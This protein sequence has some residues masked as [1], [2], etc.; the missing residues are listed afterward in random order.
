M[1]VLIILSRWLHIIA[2]VLAF[3]GTFFMRVILPLGLAQAD[4]AS[5]DAVFLRCRRVF[6]MLIHTAVLLLLLTGAFNT[7]S[8]WNDYKLNT[9][10]MHGLWG[11]HML[12][13]I[14]AMIIALVLL[15]PPQPPRWHKTGAAINLF[16]LLTAVFLA[17][18]LKYVR[19]STMRNKANGL[20]VAT[21]HHDRAPATTSPTTLPTP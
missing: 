7:Y 6:K 18:T 15:A 12:L 9:R 8:A 20:P 17:S 3:G 13:G 19:D 21:H 2:A 14:I 16:L 5:R 11:P 4:A 1:V 10:L